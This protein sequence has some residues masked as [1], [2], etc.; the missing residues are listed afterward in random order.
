M[1]NFTNLQISYEDGIL[2]IYEENG[3]GCSYS[4]DAEHE[5]ATTI[6]EYLTGYYEDEEGK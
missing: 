4:V 5:I 3:S 2:Y 6:A 1:K